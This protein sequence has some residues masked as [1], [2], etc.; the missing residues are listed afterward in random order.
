MAIRTKVTRKMVGTIIRATAKL[1]V[2]EMTERIA[3]KAITPVRVKVLVL[4]VLA[5]KKM[6]VKVV[7]IRMIRGTRKTRVV[8]FSWPNP[9]NLPI[10]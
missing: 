5:T 3:V 4:T 10:T 8:A 7:T 6:E 1:A 2:A 9:N